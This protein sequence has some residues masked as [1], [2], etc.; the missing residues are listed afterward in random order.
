MVPPQQ[1]SALQPGLHFPTSW[2]NVFAQSSV[3]PTKLICFKWVWK[4]TNRAV[5]TFFV[6]MNGRLFF[7]VANICV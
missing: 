7:K 4:P 3:D 5:G 6:E 1:G 2:E